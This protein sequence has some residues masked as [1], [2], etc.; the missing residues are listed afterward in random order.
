MIKYKSIYNEVKKDEK[1]V[2]LEKNYNK[3]I[4]NLYKIEK[5]INDWFYSGKG[6]DARKMDSKKRYKLEDTWDE[7]F[8]MASNT[9]EWNDY[10]K[11]NR[12]SK[13]YRFT[14]VLA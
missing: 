9:K 6:N 12:K 4:A 14:D 8:N 11:E 7:L 2:S 10:T 3:D 13:Q 1:Y 5:E